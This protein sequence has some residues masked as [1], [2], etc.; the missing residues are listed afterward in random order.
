MA[1][2]VMSED[3]NQPRCW[4]E[5]SRYRSAGARSPAAALQHAGVG[6]A[7]VEPH[8]EG[9]VDLLV[10]PA[11]ASPSRSSGV[12]SNQASMPFSSTRWA[13]CSIR[14]GCP[15]EARRSAC[16]SGAG[17]ARPRCAG[18]RCT[19][20]GGCAPCPRCG[21]GPSRASS[22][23]GD[24]AQRRG[25]QPAAL[26]ADEPLGGGAEDDGGLVAPAVGIAVG[27][28]GLAQQRAA[29][30]EHLHHRSLAVKT[31]SPANSGVPGRKRPS[32]PTGLS[33]F[34]AVAAADDVVLQ[35]VAG[36][37]VDRAG[38]GLQ[39][40][41]LAED[42]RAPRGRRRGAGASAPRRRRRGRSR[43]PGSARR[44]SGPWCP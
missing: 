16:R 15:G 41:V 4:S 21:T 3:W 1:T 9:V 35:A 18:A 44:R 28:A 40:D 20:P 34:Q 14:P 2:E 42:D 29:G 23:P 25:A 11:P 13:T 32:P 38:A 33:T 8:V 6:D 31:C 17:S 27:E 36:G 19:S 24:L 10:A 43:S 30:L 37:G 39:G 22:A 26:H 7:G 5:P 12:S